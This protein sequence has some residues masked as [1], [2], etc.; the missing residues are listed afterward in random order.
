[1]ELP[2]CYDGTGVS[3]DVGAVIVVLV[4]VVVVVVVVDRYGECAELG[5]ATGPQ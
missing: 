5:C 1:V 4:V 3:H 2:G